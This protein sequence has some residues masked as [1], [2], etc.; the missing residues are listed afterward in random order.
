MHK[1]CAKK[2]N[3]CV[4]NKEVQSGSGSK[5]EQLH[6]LFLKSQRPSKQTGPGA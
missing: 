5:K 2:K 1:V 3:E 6:T 4:F